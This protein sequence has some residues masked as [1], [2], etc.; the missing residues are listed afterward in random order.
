MKK[1]E[2]PK[3]EVIELDPKDIIS[4]SGENPGTS[5]SGGSPCSPNT[6]IL[7]CHGETGNQPG[8]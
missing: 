5:N 4:S 2:H 1:Y 3:M 7:P 8:C 6:P